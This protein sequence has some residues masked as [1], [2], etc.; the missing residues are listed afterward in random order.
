MA[1][2]MGRFAAP[3]ACPR[4]MGDVRSPKDPNGPVESNVAPIVVTVLRE[5][6][7]RQ[8]RRSQCFGVHSVIPCIAAL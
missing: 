3:S 8:Y 5:S 6:G 7:D 1:V 2:E 4:R